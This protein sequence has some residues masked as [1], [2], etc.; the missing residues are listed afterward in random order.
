MILQFCWSYILILRFSLLGVSLNKTENFFYP[1]LSGIC[2]L[3]CLNTV[4]LI[5]SIHLKIVD[6]LAIDLDNVNYFGTE[7][8]VFGVCCISII[9]F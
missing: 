3:N 6:T 9:I 2:Q 7:G 1:S 8:I 5:Y 4:L